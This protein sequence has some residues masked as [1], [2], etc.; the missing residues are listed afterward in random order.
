LLL[1][2]ARKQAHRVTSVPVRSL[3]KLI[4]VL[5]AAWKQCPRASL[6]MMKMNKLKVRCVKRRG[7]N[8]MVR[9]NDY[10]DRMYKEQS[11]EI[12]SKT[13]SSTDDY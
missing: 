8:G 13:A 1:R 3:A 6:Y 11:T 2:K 5:T 7:W 10:L 4:S 12:S 9:L